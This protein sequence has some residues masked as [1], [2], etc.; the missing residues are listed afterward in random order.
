M[1]KL[2]LLVTMVMLC[3]SFAATNSPARAEKAAQSGPDVCPIFHQIS[4]QVYSPGTNGRMGNVYPGEVYTIEFTVVGEITVQVSIVNNGM[5]FLEGPRTVSGGNSVT[6]IYTV[7]SSPI[8]GGVGYLIT[9]EGGG[10]ETV[11]S[12]L[13]APST[14]VDVQASCGSSVAVAGCTTRMNITSTAVVGQFVTNT[15]TYWR[16]GDLTNNPLITIPAGQTAWVLGIDAT[17]QY[18]KIVWVCNYLWVPISDMG[19]NPD[20]VWNS[21]PLPTGT[22]Q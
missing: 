1:K 16:P 13:Q 21:A 18:Y 12:R 10:E 17:G 15:P 9:G 7:P 22:V 2:L 8:P 6:L 14:Y 20:A 19:P 5:Q 4:D 3:L 11:A